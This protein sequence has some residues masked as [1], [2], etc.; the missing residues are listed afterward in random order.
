MNNLIKTIIPLIDENMSLEDLDESTGFIDCYLE[1]KNRPWLIDHIFLMYKWGD[2]KSTKIF[3]KFR[4]MKSFYGYR[5]VYINKECYIVYTF[6]I[7]PSI[8]SLRKGYSILRD[9]LKLR[10][11]R[12]WQ[13]K[14]DWISI[15]VMKDAITCGPVVS[16]LPEE[17][18]IHE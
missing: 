2:T 7:N 5:I 3:Y 1:D 18:Y 4:A 17:D 11:L 10:I 8:K 16:I 15:N 13:F 6:T 12:F 14:D 9:N